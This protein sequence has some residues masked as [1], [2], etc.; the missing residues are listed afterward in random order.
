MQIHRRQ[1]KTR[2]LR[3][4]CKFK[5]GQKDLIITGRPQPIPKALDESQAHG[6]AHKGC[7]HP[8]SKSLA[9]IPRK[10]SQTGPP[11][12]YQYRWTF[13]SHRGIRRQQIF[14]G[15]SLKYPRVTRAYSRHSQLRQIIRGNHCE[16]QV[17][18]GVQAPRKGL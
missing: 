2:L 15:K 17:A 12:K 11:H 10:E 5:Q 13:P 16:G 9:N 3:A 14:I 7:T 1:L 4:P 8:I 6:I 18:K